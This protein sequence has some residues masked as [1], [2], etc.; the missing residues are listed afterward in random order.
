MA[1]FK[2][3]HALMPSREDVAKVAAVPYDVV[4][5]EEAAALAEGNALSFL[6][7]SR[8][9][10]ELEAGIDLHDAIRC[11]IRCAVCC[12]ICCAVSVPLILEN[13]IIY[14]GY[15]CAVRCSVSVYHT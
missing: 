4:N 3:F 13:V 15:S 14:K 1:I 2:P 7:V 5:T 10:I 12:F 9:E 8:P 6:R 11:A